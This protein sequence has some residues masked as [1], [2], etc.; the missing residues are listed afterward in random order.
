M[1]TNAKMK[2]MI[3]IALKLVKTWKVHG[4]ANSITR[5]VMKFQLYGQ[6]VHLGLLNILGAL[7]TFEKY[8]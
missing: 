2:V 5:P 3:V 4:N 8:D 7:A 6:V 1:L